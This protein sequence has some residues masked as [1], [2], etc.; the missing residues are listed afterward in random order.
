MTEHN[1]RR[2][3]RRRGPKVKVATETIEKTPGV[4]YVFGRHCD[5][6]SDVDGIL[7]YEHVVADGHVKGSLPTRPWRL[8]EN[9][10]KRV[11]DVGPLSGVS[12]SAVS[13]REH[14]NGH[15]GQAKAAR[16]AKKFVRTRIRFHENAATRR[17]AQE[18]QE[19]G[20]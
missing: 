3:P 9:V 2:P 18:A 10:C 5:V 6:K 4:T 11:S 12:V 1:H 17:L 14:S 7:T 13:G 16:G 8:N 19:I 20:D 15:R